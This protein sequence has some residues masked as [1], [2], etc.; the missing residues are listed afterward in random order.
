MDLEANK[1][2]SWEHF[3]WEASCTPQLASDIERRFGGIGKWRK[4]SMVDSLVLVK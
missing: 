2:K 3:V 1:G 4:D